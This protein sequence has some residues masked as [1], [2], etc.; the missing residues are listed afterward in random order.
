MSKNIMAIVSAA[1]FILLVA[2]AIRAWKSRVA[3][4]EASFE[5]PL[6]A[7]EYFGA[8]VAAAKCF[9]VATTFA[10]NVLERIAAYGLGA[11]GLAQV[12]VFS[13]GVLIVR[14][15]EKPLAIDKAAINSVTL[16]QV[17]I[18]KAVESGGLVQI[19][20][21]QSGVALATHLRIVDPSVRK[22]VLT[23]VSSVITKEVSK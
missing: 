16:G 8:S 18:D 23:A 2:V 14:N 4:Q 5:A 10:E 1:L 6:E 17:A 20:W 7:L 19:N 9:Y 21:T 15:G 12:L 3:N 13:E 22:Q 11:R